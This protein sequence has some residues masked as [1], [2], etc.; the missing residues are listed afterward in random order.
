[1]IKYSSNNMLAWSLHNDNTLAHQVVPE[2]TE[3]NLNSNHI[4]VFQLPLQYIDSRGSNQRLSSK[5]AEWFYSPF[6]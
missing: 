3:L 2:S 4:T 1:M 5:K 6:F